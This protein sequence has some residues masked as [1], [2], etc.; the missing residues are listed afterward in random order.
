MKETVIGAVFL[1]SWLLCGC[2]VD[3]MLDDYR[4]CLIVVVTLIVV[5]VSAALITNGDD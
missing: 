3:Y 5:T 1:F 4:S 2:A